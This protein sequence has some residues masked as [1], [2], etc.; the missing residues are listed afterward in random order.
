MVF[1][2]NIG[3]HTMLRSFSDICKVALDVLRVAAAKVR[4]GSWRG[5]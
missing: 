5:V 4:C 2:H 1:K 3:L